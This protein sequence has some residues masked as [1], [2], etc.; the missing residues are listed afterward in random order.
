VVAIGRATGADRHEWDLVTFQLYA[1]GFRPH[2]L[3]AGLAACVM[4]PLWASAH[5]FGTPLSSAWPPTLWHGHEMLFG[6]LAVAIAGF[7]LTAVPSWT[8]GRG[9]AG[10]PLV[11]VSSLWL[12]G[13]IC[14]AASSRLPPA[15]VAAVDV[16]F[17]PSIGGLVLPSL[18]R[19]RSRNAV[20]LIV[21]AVLTLAN[22][23]FHVALMKGDAPLAG[24]ALLAGID[25][26]LIL[27]TIIGGRIVPAFSAATLKARGHEGV[28]RA[29]PG[30]GPIA[31][32]AMIAVLLTDVLRPDSFVAG[33]CAGFAA[34]VQALRLSRW[35]STQVLHEPLVWV[36]HLAYAWLPV[37]LALKAIALLS[38]AALAAFWLHALTIGAAASMVLAVMTRAALGHTGRPL[39]AAPLTVAAYLLLLG[40]TLVR[41]FGLVALPRGYLLVI[42][43]AAALWTAAFGA[44]LAVYAPI[45]CAPR[46]DGKL[47]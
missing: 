40:A 45:L 6:F 46:A 7:L 28:R 23:V 2:F 13:R 22:L 29:W 35:R 8:G 25:V 19:A 33:W 47:G 5:V 39:V 32:G 37:G 12:L 30:L 9:F 21:L 24:R 15:I 36:L 11:F 34:L 1:Y 41:V 16:A 17:L 31:I 27:V 38:G 43:L 4:I 44:F 3:A 26:V 14:V 10:A 20:L 18:V 42:L